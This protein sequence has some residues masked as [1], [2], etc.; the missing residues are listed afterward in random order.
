MA[1]LGLLKFRGHLEVEALL[2]WRNFL[3]VT[4]DSAPRR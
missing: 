3:E 1:K 2:S 4:I